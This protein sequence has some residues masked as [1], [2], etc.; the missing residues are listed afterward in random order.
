M[1]L[2][3]KVRDG[4]GNELCPPGEGGQV[5]V[6]PQGRGHGRPGKV[7]RPLGESD[8]VARHGGDVPQPADERQLLGQSPG[9]PLA[10]RPRAWHRI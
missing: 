7:P 5:E 1:D 6:L 10:W 4:F 3:Y 8:P 9:I 2:L